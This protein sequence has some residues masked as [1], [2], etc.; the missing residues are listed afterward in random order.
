VNEADKRNFEVTRGV[1]NRSIATTCIPTKHSFFREGHASEGIEALGES[2]VLGKGC[3]NVRSSHLV[4][5]V[6]GLA[7][8]VREGLT[9]FAVAHAP[10][11]SLRVADVTFQNPAPASQWMIHVWSL[12]NA[13][14][15]GHAV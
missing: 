10:A 6:A 12:L 4:Q 13:A 7:Q 15:P 3:D 5:N 1:A 14:W 9:V 8:E 11:H 2:E